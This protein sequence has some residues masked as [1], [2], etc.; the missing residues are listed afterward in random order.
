MKRVIV[1]IHGID[2]KLNHI[3]DS[4]VLFLF[5]I[6]KSGSSILNSIVAAMARSQLVNYVD[7]AGAFFIG[8]VPVGQWNKDDAVRFLARPG[9]L[10]AGFR[11]FPV[12]MAG[13]KSFDAAKK[14]LLVRD[15][16]DALVSEY[17]SN[18][19]THG[20]PEAGKSREE[21][22]NLRE[23]AKLIDLSDFVVKRAPLMRRTI[24][25]YSP[26][27]DRPNTLVLRYE[28]VILRKEILID[29]I[30]N[31][32]GWSIPPL[33]KSQILSWADVVPQ[34]EN[35]TNFVRKV[36]PGDHI[37]KLSTPTIDQLNDILHPVLSV[38]GYHQK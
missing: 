18:A 24:L 38:F 7:V 25:A 11:D 35:Q 21:M 19:A 17:F 26:I 30:S 9:N 6:R 31:H 15:P 12:K 10:L 20:V 23:E 22:L 2:F 14:V 34:S 1:N 37:E 36:V 32:Y 5:G 3:D 28:D 33:L 29:S 13:S 8:G 16:R 4:E 27:L